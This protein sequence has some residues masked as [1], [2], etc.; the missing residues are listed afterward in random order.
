MI[1]RIKALVLG[2]GGAVPEK[3]METDVAAVALLIEAA[4][5][6]GDFGAAERAAIAALIEERFGLAGAD[7][8]DLITAGSMAVEKSHQLFAFTRVLKQGF[9]AGQRQQ[10]IE[11]LWEVA[12][13]DG[14]VHDYEANLVRRVC[15]LLH[16]SDRDSG[17]AKKRVLAKLQ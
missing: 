6:D 14:V 4:I 1:E 16:V 12:Y 13:A 10:M 3:A 8:E 11:M 5:M 9:D 7:V 17:A 15:G 2:G